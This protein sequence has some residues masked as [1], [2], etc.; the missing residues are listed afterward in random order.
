[1]PCDRREPDGGAA[2]VEFALIVPL[3]LLLVF[4]MIDF[5]RAYNMQLAL[6][7]AAREG[8]RPIALREAGANATTATR[9]AIPA[10]S[11]IV[12][13]TVGVTAITCPGG[14]LSL[15]VP[16]AKVTATKTFTFLTP[17]LGTLANLAK[18]SGGS[19]LGGSFTITGQGVMRCGG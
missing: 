4:G 16:N 15:P 2:A 17:G 12:A 18:R 3:F 7:E 14:V 10:G 9:A 13:S 5:G 6:T 11:G 8:V 19:S 1:M